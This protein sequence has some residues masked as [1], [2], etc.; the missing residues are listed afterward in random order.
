VRL[1]ATNGKKILGTS[2]NLPID[3][4]I[5]TRRIKPPLTRARVGSGYSE[6]WRVRGERF[7]GPESVPPRIARRK[8]ARFAA[9]TSVDEDHQIVITRV[10]QAAMQANRAEELL[11]RLLQMIRCEHVWR[12]NEEPLRCIQIERSSIE[13]LRDRFGGRV[14]SMAIDHMTLARHR[15]CQLA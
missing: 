13:Q 15:F 1:D 2:T 8:R 6:T 4:T 3:D 9:R 10:Q 7:Q 14:A 12:I 5:N 11:C